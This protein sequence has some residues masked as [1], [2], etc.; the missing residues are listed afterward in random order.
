MKNQRRAHR[1][2][3]EQIFLTAA[4]LFTEKGYD[5]VSIREICEKVGVGKPT[6]YYYFQDK[7]S[8]LVA[9]IDEAYRLGFDYF[10]RYIMPHREWKHKFQGLLKAAS[11]YSLEYPAL[12]RFFLLL[13]QMVFPPNVGKK[14]EALKRKEMDFLIDLLKEGKRAK[15]I[16]KKVNLNILLVLLLGAI[17]LLVTK[18]QSSDTPY[19]WHEHDIEELFMFFSNNILQGA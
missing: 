7:E 17:Q 9:L 14:V 15:C 8:L 12:I 16:S 10:S 13:P 3:R 2:T 19:P 18:P 1:N 5:A 6:L 11:V 4:E